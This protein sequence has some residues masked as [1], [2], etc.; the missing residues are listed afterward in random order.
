[1]AR[2]LGS[3]A[4][5]YFMV[6]FCAA[7]QFLTKDTLPEGSISEACAEALIADIACP[8]QVR[9][10]PNSRYFPEAALEE[11]CTVSCTAAL[12]N[13]KDEVASSCGASNYY[14]LSGSKI[15]PAGC[16]VIAGAV[17][18]GTLK[19]DECDYC[20]IK[21]Y[22]FI[23]GSPLY[24]GYD[25][26]PDYTAL[27]QRCSKTGFPLPPTSSI[28]LPVPVPTATNTIPTPTG[29]TGSIYTIQQGDTCQSVSEAQSVGTAQLLVDNGLE[30]YCANFPTQ[31]G[32]CIENTCTAYI[33]LTTWN[34]ILGHG[35]RHI[36]RSVGNTIC[37]S[38]PGDDKWS[39]ITI[40]SATLTTTATATAAPVP[41]DLADG[42]VDRC[43]EFY[44]V[45]PGDYC[46][47][48]IIKYGISLGDFL[49]LN[50]GLNQNCTNLF[51]YESYCIQPA[52]PI[53]EYPGHPGYVTPGDS[54]TYLPGTEFPIATYIPEPVANQTTLLPLAPGT[55]GDCYMYTDGSYLQVDL[56][57][58]SYESACH[59]LADGQ[60]IDLDTLSNWNPSLN[61][62][63][64]DCAFEEEY[65]YCIAPYRTSITWTPGPTATITL[66]T[67]S[68]STTETTDPP[69]TTT[70]TGGPPGPTQSGIPENCKK[71]HLV[72]EGDTC[73]DLSQE[74]GS[75]LDQLYQWNPAIKNN[76]AEGFWLGN[77]Y[78]VGVAD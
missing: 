63:S 62:S 47:K 69:A 49:F 78:C 54:I 64:Q 11:A 28:D 60:G 16:H 5:V 20:L 1:M 58:G 7:T 48:I 23:A 41:T 74:N 56:G 10:F 24:A 15:A 21:Q 17:A 33:Q 31:G 13:Y 72:E 25:L 36:G 65:R 18:E 43:A 27:T 42:T 26:M 19:M 29:C 76:C 59:L 2:H 44:L 22:Q 12:A 40:P 67:S 32:L 52:G 14:T 8:A 71:W 3:W 57:A 73:W 35:C 75:T 51:A 45:Q 61:S 55:R 53:D 77:A 46:N 70:I 38:P 34:P 37:L 66:I 68:T 30:A 4:L 9:S 39:P 6:R 50:Q